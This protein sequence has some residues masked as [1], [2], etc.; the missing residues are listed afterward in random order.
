MSQ[1]RD[2]R[3]IQPKQPRPGSA[4]KFLRRVDLPGEPSN[5]YFNGTL[6]VL[7]GG[8]DMEYRGIIV[9]TF[10]VSASVPDQDRRAT[11]AEMDI[12]RRDFDMEDAEEDNHSPGVARHLFRPAHLPKGTVGICG[13]KEDEEEVVEPDGYKWQRKVD[14]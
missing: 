4:W 13:C 10:H 7:S 2:L 6:G 5:Q 8:T 3:L 14:E 11:D 9:P 12:V 1:K